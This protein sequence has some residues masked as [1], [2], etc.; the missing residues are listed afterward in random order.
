MPAYRID[1]LIVIISTSLVLFVVLGVFASIVRRRMRERQ[2]V[3]RTL[4]EK[5][6]AEELIRLAESEGGRA[7]MRD[8]FGGGTPGRDELLRQAMQMIFAG[9]ACGG[10]AAIMRTPAIGV[11]GLVLVAVG[12]AQALAVKLLRRSDRT[13]D[14]K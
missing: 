5:L 11:V 12:L 3:R 13:S 1:N 8:M 10:A 14:E 9:F 4:M 7:W 2:E 6:S